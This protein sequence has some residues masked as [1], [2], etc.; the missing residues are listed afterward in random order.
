MVADWITE[1][2]DCDWVTDA[3]ECGV[4]EGG[5]VGDVAVG[6][7][8]GD[9]ELLE[10]NKDLDGE[11]DDCTYLKSPWREA[12]SNCCWPLKRDSST[13]YESVRSHHDL[14]PVNNKKIEEKNN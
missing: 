12:F 10:H 7:H 3:G 5:D 4:E 6:E 14:F 11:Y 13:V 9:Y 2:G 1:A 8:V